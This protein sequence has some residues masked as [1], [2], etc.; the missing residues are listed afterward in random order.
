[1]R[2]SILADFVNG[3]IR[4]GLYPSCLA[5]ISAD[6]DLLERILTA[7]LTGM[8][9]ALVG[10]PFDALKISAQTGAPLQSWGVAMGAAKASATPTVLRAS[11]VTVAQIASY[12]AAKERLCERVEGPILFVS[13]GLFSGFMAAT[14]SAPVDYMRTRAVLDLPVN[15]RSPRTWF[16]GW[17]ASFSRLGPLFVI[18]WPLFEWLRLL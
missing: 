7:S 16:T 3:A 18:S 1:M 13:A 2:Y 12:E 4:V 15:W 8:C 14:V 9:G 10:S 6:P 11:L 5:T 17:V